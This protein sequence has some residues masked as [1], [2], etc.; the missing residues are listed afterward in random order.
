[1]G[2]PPGHPILAERIR[3]MDPDVCLQEALDIA[4]D[5]L[6]NPEWDADGCSH[7]N[8]E[9]LAERIVSLNDWIQR[10]GFL[11]SAWSKE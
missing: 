9:T 4:R 7:E 5:I 3:T 6:V 10:G 2:I 11:P 8:V 1:M